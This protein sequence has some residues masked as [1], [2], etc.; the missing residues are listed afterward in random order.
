MQA[1]QG[2]SNVASGVYMRV[3]ATFGT[4]VAVVL[5]AAALAYGTAFVTGAASA[6]STVNA[7]TVGAPAAIA[8]RAGERDALTT[9]AQSDANSFRGGERGDGSSSSAATTNDFRAGERGDAK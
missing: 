8:F 4:L 9:T 3:M 1:T 5:I 7:Q 6:D 2:R